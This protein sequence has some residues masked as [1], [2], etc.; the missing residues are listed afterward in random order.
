M[1]TRKLLIISVLLVFALSAPA[2]AATPPLAATPWIALTNPN[3]IT[4]WQPST[5][6]MVPAEPMTVWQ[7]GRDYE[8]VWDFVGISGRVQVDLMK[9]G[10]VFKTLSP[11]DGTFIGH[12]GKGFQ[13][14][15]MA[16]EWIAT[17]PYQ[18]RVSS[19]SIPG[20]SSTSEVFSIIAKQ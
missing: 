1:S 14:V 4:I 15:S 10:K 12:D 5:G 18:I 20:I 6:S 17:S 16:T 19:L 3:P 2:F 7:P 8:V 11:S 9:D 13:R